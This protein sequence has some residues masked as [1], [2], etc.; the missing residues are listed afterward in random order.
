ML[1]FSRSRAVLLAVGVITL[2]SSACTPPP[3]VKLAT[4]KPGAEAKQPPAPTKPAAKSATKPVAKPVG[5]PSEN[6]KSALDKA[7][8][9][10]SISQSA[11][12][13]DDWNLVVSRWEQAITLLKQVPTNDPSKKLVGQKLTEYQASLATARTRAERSGKVNVPTL[14]PLIAA[15]PLVTTGSGEV[16]LNQARIKYRESRIP[17]IEVMFNGGQPFDMMVDTGAS[18]TMITP[19][20]ARALEVQLV[21]SSTAMTP[22]GPTEVMIGVVKSMQVGRRTVRN[23]QV[24]IGPVR[25]LGH[26]FFGICDLTIRQNVVEFGQCG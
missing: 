9:A 5:K 15:D 19:D 7:D 3:A 13:P 2:G 18:G 14:D 22:A 20:M 26:D 1:K 6:Y 11:Q 23:I 17:V 8:A 4:V 12:S 25:L 24:S 10:Q 21:G 16:A